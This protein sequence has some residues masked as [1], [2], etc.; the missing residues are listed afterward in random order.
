M[1]KKERLNKL[2]EKVFRKVIGIKRETYYNAMLKEYIIY[3][4]T[5]RPPSLRR[6][7]FS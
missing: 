5:K 7:S 6:W 1:T 4:K 2:S 3:K